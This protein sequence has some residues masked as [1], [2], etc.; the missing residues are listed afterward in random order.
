VTARDNRRVEADEIAT[1][2][3]WAQGEFYP[4]AAE[5]RDALDELA[6]EM[7][8]RPAAWWQAFREV[9]SE[10]DRETLRN[11]DMPFA[12]LLSTG[13][14]SVWDEVAA[15]A[16]SDRKIANAFWAG[17]EFARLSGEAYKRL[18]RRMTIEAFVRHESRLG[19]GREPV[20]AW[21]DRWSGDVLFYLTQEDPEEAW[22]MAL[23]LLAVKD[24]PDWASTIAA[25]LIEDLLHDHGDAFIERLEAEAAHNER[26]RMGL[27]TTQWMV[28][29]HLLDRV[30]FAAGACWERNRET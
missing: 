27:P 3:R 13:G 24:D 5:Q 14:E 7:A 11:L 2:K 9:L 16:R 6:D 30:R 8:K 17:M 26:L 4:L 21:E 18:G 25:F 29:E 23:D 1:L 19:K 20:E 12:A 15:V 22:A 10:S 28:P